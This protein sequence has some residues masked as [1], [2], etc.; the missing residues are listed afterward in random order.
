MIPKFITNGVKL[1]FFRRKWR[2][3]NP[4]NTTLPMNLFSMDVVSVGNMSYGDITVKVFSTQ[5][6]RLII[7]DYVSIAQNVIFILGGNHQVN[8]ITPYPLFSKLVAPS[9]EKDA[10]SKGPV[11]IENE[12]WIGFGSIIL[13]GVTVGKGAIIAAGSVVVTDIPPYAIAGGNPAKVIRYRFEED[14]R[15]RLRDFS[16][17]QIDPGIIKSNLDDFYKPVNTELLQKIIGLRH[18]RNNNTEKKKDIEPGR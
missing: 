17:A 9:P 6:E 2:R 4:H 15:E 18:E 11:V 3:S 16:I 1:F 12:A 10:T 8:T 13:S 7:G 14:I 5:T